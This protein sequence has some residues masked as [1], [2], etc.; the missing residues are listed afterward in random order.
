MA[1]TH[2]VPAEPMWPKIQ[3]VLDHKKMNANQLAVAIG[4]SNGVI[5]HIRRD[6]NYRPSFELME[7]IADALDVSMDTFRQT[8]KK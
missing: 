6:P 2:Y 3:K 7:R 5:Y 1:R 8:E 4:S